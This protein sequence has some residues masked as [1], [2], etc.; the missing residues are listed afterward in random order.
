MLIE[1]CKI[2]SNILAKL[3]VDRGKSLLSALISISI[4]SASF[5]L[6]LFIKNNIVLYVCSCTL[7][8]SFPLVF[9]PMLS[10]YTKK[11]SLEDNQFDGMTIRD[12]FIFIPRGPV[13]LPYLFFP[14]F[15][16]Q[17]GIG[18]A[19]A[20]SMIFTTTKVLKQK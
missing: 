18:I 9:V 10:A 16:L 13:Y 17:F 7:G 12:V 11:I 15:I 4:M 8:V 2:A 14:N 5:I 6:L 3:L 1:I 19:C 20:G